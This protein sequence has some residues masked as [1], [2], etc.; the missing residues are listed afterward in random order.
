MLENPFKKI[1]HPPKEVPVILKKQVMNDVA[2][3]KLFIEMTSLFTINYTKAAESFM[4]L[5]NKST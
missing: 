3:F 5:K 1:G 2:A 4:K